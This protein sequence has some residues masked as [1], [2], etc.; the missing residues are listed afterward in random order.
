MVAYS[1]GEG[2]EVIFGLNGG[3]GLPC[4]YFR[5]PLVPLAEHGYRVVIHDQLGTGASDHPT[6]P[7]LW[8]LGAT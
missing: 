5:D 8:T 6:D 4:D 3:P 7:A 2:E 1:Y